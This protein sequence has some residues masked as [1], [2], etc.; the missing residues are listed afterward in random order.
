MQKN[1]VIINKKDREKIKKEVLEEIND[2]VK[3]ELVKDVLEDVKEQIDVEYKDEL[4]E[5]IANELVDDIKEQIKK[6]ES[7]LSFRKSFKIFRM[8]I[9]IIILLCLCIYLIY[10]LY[11]HQDLKILNKIRPTTTTTTTSTITT[12]T[13]E[14]KD[15]NWYKNQYGYLIDNIKIS[16]PSLVNSNNLIKDLDI[17][18]LLTISYRNLDINSI[19]IEDTIYSIEETYLQSEYTKLFGNN[20]EYSPTNFTVDGLSFVYSKT[21]KAYIAIKEEKE[22]QTE[23]I[24]NDIYSIEENDKNIE[25]TCFVA[26]IK[27]NKVYNVTNLEESIANYIDNMNISSIN[28]NLS[29]V[30]YT[31]SL[32]NGTYVL[33]SI[34]LV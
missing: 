6:D 23:R 24:V 12:T 15:L 17:K 18:D 33:D 14:V 20:K 30:K 16:N 1:E 2:T 4:K 34:N 31:F 25:I 27:D 9:Y 28:D 7:K 11:N 5:K 3:E 22:E 13:K 26:Y 8:Y 21:K 29:K 10:I 19:N 32:Y